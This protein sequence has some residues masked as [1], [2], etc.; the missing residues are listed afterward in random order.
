MEKANLKKNTENNISPSL[1]ESEDAYLLSLA[2]ERLS[3]CDPAT[4]IPQEEVWRNLGMTEADLVG[5]DD[6]E[7]E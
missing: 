7:I 2:I 1:D 5:Y 3:H 6:V 4:V